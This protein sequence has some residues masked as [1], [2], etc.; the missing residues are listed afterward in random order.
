VQ[1]IEDELDLSSPVLAFS[2]AVRLLCLGL[3]HDWRDSPDDYDAEYN[4]YPILHCA[5]CGKQ[6]AFP[7]WKALDPLWRMGRV[8][9][10]RVLATE[11]AHWVGL[12]VL[13]GLAIAGV[14]SLVALGAGA[15]GTHEVRT[16]V[17]AL[18]AVGGVAILGAAIADPMAYEGGTAFTFGRGMIFPRTGWKAGSLFAGPSPNIA[19]NPAAGRLMRVDDVVY[20]AGVI[21]IGIGA[22]LHYVA[23]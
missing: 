7:P 9:R 5:R 22:L 23:T 2:M 12:A 13:V 20:A 6:E 21:L 4:E 18:V 14:A 10:I 3:G 11:A 8:A 16:L 15:R 1:A 19:S 17:I